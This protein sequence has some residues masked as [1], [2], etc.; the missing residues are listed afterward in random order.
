MRFYR[1]L[2]FLI[3]LFLIGCD[4]A[5][6]TNMDGNLS[7]NALDFEFEFFG[8]SGEDRA[9]SMITTQDGG[10]AVFGF[11]DSPEIKT[12][13]WGE[14]NMDY[15]LMKF[16]S[17]SQM[18]WQRTYGGSGDDRGQSLIQ[19]DDGGFL[20]VGYAQS[21]D[22]DATV[23]KGFHDNWILKVNNQGVVEW[24]KSFGFSGHDH[25]YDVVRTTDGNYVFVGFLDVSASNGQGAT[26]RFNSIAAH[27]VGEFWVTKINPMGDIIWRKY[28]GGTNNDRAYSVV[29][30]TDGGVMIAGASESQDFDISNSR[31][32]YD[33]WILKLD[34]NGLLQME[35]S[36]GG[37]GI[38]QGRSIIKSVHGN[39][40]ITGNSFSQDGDVSNPLGAADAWTICIDPTGKL[41]WQKSHGGSDF[42]DAQGIIDFSESSFLVVGNSKS[43][44][45]WVGH[46]EGENDIWLFQ[47]EE[48]GNLVWET[49]F[50]GAGMDFGRDLIRLPSN[51]FLILGETESTLFYDR[52]TS[53]ISDVVL[54]KAHF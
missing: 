48:G 10:F 26:S 35:K 7:V 27:G 4:D 28:F 30:T 49:S 2:Y 25:A 52:P 18:E 34:K 42:E 3:V 36:F 47:I 14:A 1:A 20:L 6:E 53:G 44:D 46:N 29:S 38:D 50:G 41:L 24:E 21:A 17:N 19:T 12:H 5:Y 40:L 22:G 13:L 15:W 37:G 16:D 43:N 45:Q 23:N 8:G 9:Q 39:F 54:I 33:Y 32:S 11:T 31:G 51:D